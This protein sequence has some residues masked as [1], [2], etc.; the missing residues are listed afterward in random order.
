MKTLLIAFI[1]TLAASLAAAPQ[2]PTREEALKALERGARFFRTEVSVQGTYLW[3]Y[4]DDLAKREGEGKAT[5][6]QGWV[7]PPGTPSVG[8]AFLSAWQATSNNYYLD[9]ARE[10]AHALARGQLLSGGWTYSIDFSD[11]GRR[12]LAYRDG[13]RKTARNFT[14][15]DDDTTQCAVRFLMRTDA[16]LGFRD[17][18]I[19]DMIDYALSSMLKAQYPNGA[20]PQGFDQFPDP[21]KFPVQ[22]ASYPD[23]WPRTWPGASNYWLRYTLNDNALARTIETLFEAERIYRERDADDRFNKLGAQCRAAAMKAGDFIL[24]T[25]MPEPQPAWAQQYDFE[26]RPTWARKFEPPSVTGGESQGV[27][28]TLM[29]LYTETG[30]AKYLEPIPRAL[31]YLRRSRLPNG[32]LA[33]FYELR[34][35]KP[36][37]FTKTY[38]LTY[39]DGD[40]PTHYAFK[41]RDDTDAIAREFERVKNLSVLDLKKN[42]TIPPR[43]TDA[44]RKE[45]S[46]IIAA[47]D[48][49]GRWIEEGRL[50]YHGPND[51]T[52]RVIRSATFADHV[53]TLCRFITVIP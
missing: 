51:P 26:T 37:Y 22:R 20:W 24:R 35:N 30:D 13:G 15:F 47:Q 6:T 34:S 25:Q 45:V 42:P 1:A 10:T 16:A 29:M 11:E 44:L 36:L 18:K 8:L 12:K 9:A 17:P 50:R 49:R 2:T 53:E 5:A 32:Q 38:E 3:Q 40:M 27:I 28:R 46:A 52:T 19:R 14:T 39:D 43:V 48:A 33:R 21:N 41:V 7:Q 23:T 31:N 4:S